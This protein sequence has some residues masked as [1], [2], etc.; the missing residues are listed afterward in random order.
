MADLS[1]TIEEDGGGDYTSV[2]AALDDNEQDLTDGGGDTLTLNIQGEWDNPDTDAVTID[3]Y[4]TGVANYI[5]IVTDSTARHNGIAWDKAKAYRLE[6]TDDYAVYNVESYVRIEGLQLKRIYSSVD[7]AITIYNSIWTNADVRIGDCIITTEGGHLTGCVQSG[8]STSNLYIYNSSFI[9]CTADG[10]SS[11]NQGIYYAYNCNFIGSGRNGISKGG[12]GTTVVKNCVLA[13]NSSGDEDGDVDTIDYCASDDDIGTNSQQ[14]DNT[15]DYEDEFNDFA[16]GDYSL[17]AGSIC[18]GNGTD[19]PDAWGQYSDD[20][21]GTIRTSTWDIGAFELAAEG[22]R[23]TKNT[24][25]AP[26][27]D[28]L[29]MSFRM[30]GL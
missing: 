3:G 15:N 12:T 19:D 10:I 16:S 23:T 20:I 5:R 8:G 22:G 29:G 28:R 24:D 27:G 2:E 25:A 9:G 14:L 17:I 18:V 30:G 4:T 1:Y 6:V 21:V 26:L 11:G 7:W 13:D